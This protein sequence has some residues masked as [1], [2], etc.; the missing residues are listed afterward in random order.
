MITNFEA[1]IHELTFINKKLSG[2]AEEEI[3][4]RYTESL[5]ASFSES[6]LRIV[7]RR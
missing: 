5:F 1:V 2:M 4:K 7:I 3:T 6:L